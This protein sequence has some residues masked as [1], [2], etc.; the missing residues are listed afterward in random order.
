MISGKLLLMNERK[1]E[2]KKERKNRQKVSYNNHT[3][4]VTVDS[5]EKNK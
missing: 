3:V 5:D 4:I 1:K 2:R